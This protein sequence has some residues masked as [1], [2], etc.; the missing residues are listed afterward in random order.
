IE[1]MRN[2]LGILQ[3]DLVLIYCGA[4]YKEKRLDFLI[5]SV[6]SLIRK[7]FNAKLIIL[8]GGP[9]EKTIKNA[10]LSRPYLLFIGPKFGREKAKFFKLSSIFL[11]PA[12]I[13]LAILDSFAF[14]TPIITT[15]HKH[16]G[17]EIEYLKNGINGIITPNDLESFTNAIIQ[18]LSNSNKLALLKENC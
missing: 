8:G 16:H 5:D 2:E 13:G 14:T 6:D 17:P 7:G 12:A 15:E 11:L 3:S 10:I 18:L 4:L 1:K 9:D